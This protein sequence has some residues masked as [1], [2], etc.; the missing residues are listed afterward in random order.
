MPPPT[1]KKGEATIFWD[2]SLLTD[3]M[4]KFSNPDIVIWNATEQT[5]QLIDITVPQDYNVVSATAN[6]IIKYEDLYI[7]IQKYGT[8]KELLL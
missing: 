1:T 5:A 6:N 2:N 7:K 4:V 8:W 3:H